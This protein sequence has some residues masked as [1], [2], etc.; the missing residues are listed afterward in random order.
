MCYL[1]DKT[2]RPE[3]NFFL[4]KESTYPDDLNTSCFLISSNKEDVGKFVAALFLLSICVF[5]GS[6][7][8]LT[9]LTKTLEPFE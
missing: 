9:R 2:G 6:R 3:H 4:D 8:F 7:S 1:D 5:R